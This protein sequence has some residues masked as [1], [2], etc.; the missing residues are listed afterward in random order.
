M[1]S[2]QNHASWYVGEVVAYFI[3]SY[4][5]SSKFLA[6]LS[7]VESGTLD[8]YGVPSITLFPQDSLQKKY[9]VCGVEDITYIVRFV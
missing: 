6:L 2:G 3:H 9:M 5:G 8:E 1:E 7:V 4:H